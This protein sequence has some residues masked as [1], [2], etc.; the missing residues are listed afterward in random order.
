MANDPV[1]SPDGQPATATATPLPAEEFEVFAEAR[2]PGLTRRLLV[3]YRHFLGLLFG[4]LE[5]YLR[6]L[7][8]DRR[9][10]PR[11]RSLWLV[12]AIS[13]NFVADR[14]LELP[15]PVQLR[16]RLEALGATYIKLG[17]VLA[18]RKDLLPE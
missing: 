14:Y 11:Y 8:A 16:R 9:F 10:G 15:F 18:L 13:R 17:Q 12:N 7:P 4:G 1:P 3:T 5:A 2:A 6:A